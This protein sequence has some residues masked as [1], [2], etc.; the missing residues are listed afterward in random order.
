[1]TPKSPCFVFLVFIFALFYFVFSSSEAKRFQKDLWDK[2]GAFNRV[3]A[4]QNLKWGNVIFSPHC[5]PACPPLAPYSEDKAPQLSSWRLSCSFKEASPEPERTLSAP[6][7]SWLTAPKSLD[8]WLKILTI[9]PLDSA[10][11]SINQT[12]G[13]YVDW[14][15]TIK[16]LLHKTQFRKERACWK[17]VKTDSIWLGSQSGARNGFPMWSLFSPH[18]LVSVL[19]QVPH[20]G[21]KGDIEALPA[22]KTRGVSR[23]DQTCLQRPRI[24]LEVGKGPESDGMWQVNLGT[25]VSTPR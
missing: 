8:S 2:V 17:L 9:L 6:H 21:M 1:M 16:W 25:Q 23:N 5:S 4:A 22:S 7:P 14:D 24:H 20:G 11:V 19:C 15:F 12:L 3:T 13:V 10:G 18:L